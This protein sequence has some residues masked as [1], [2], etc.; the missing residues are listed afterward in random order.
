MIKHCL[1]RKFQA[2]MAKIEMAKIGGRNTST[3]T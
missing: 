3:S 2:A 1:N